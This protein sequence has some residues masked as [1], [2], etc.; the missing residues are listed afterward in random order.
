[1][2]SNFTM[3]A[4]AIQ[5]GAGVLLPI[6]TIAVLS[7]KYGCRIKHFFVGVL[8]FM[9]FVLMLENR[10]HAAM[11][12]TPNGAAIQNNPLL[13]ALYGAA[14]A[15]LFEEI[16][17]YVAFRFILNR[18][19]ES[20]INAL[21]YGAGHGGFE[22]FYLLAATGANNLLMALSYRTAGMDAMMTLADGDAAVAQS[23]ADA[24]TQT[25]AW[26][27]LLSVAERCFAIAMHMGLSVLVWFAVKARGGKLSLLLL[28]IGLHFAV[29]F[30]TVLLNGKLPAAL[31]EVVVGVLAVGVVLA[32]RMVWKR[33][34]AA[35]E[36]EGAAA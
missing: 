24:V 18:D 4:M 25:P 19:M 36:S 11:L 2:V 10:F 32:A 15:G 23:F 34:A 5:A 8:V 27:F 12:S 26:M 9:V 31:L 35:A 28:A 21:S 22:C 13:L 30:I 33:Y 6:I 3:I 20:D 16:G 29:D 17:R 14:A 7:K 1:M